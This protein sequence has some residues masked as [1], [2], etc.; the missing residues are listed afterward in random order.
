MLYHLLC[1]YLERTVYMVLFLGNSLIVFN[2]QIQN[3]LHLNVRAGG[4]FV[5]YF[6]LAMI[7]MCEFYNQRKQLLSAMDIQ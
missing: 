2:M 5:F 6:V 4:V 7:L 3:V 1:H